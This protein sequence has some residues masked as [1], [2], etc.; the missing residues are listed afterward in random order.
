M[1][2]DELRQENERLKLQ[3]GAARGALDDLA[4]ELRQ[5]RAQTDAAERERDVHAQSAVQLGRMYT[6]A[7][8]D[9]EFAERERDEARAIV[10]QCRGLEKAKEAADREVSK[11][12]KEKNG[13]YQERDQCVA[14]MA[15]MAIALG[16]PAW[17]AQHDPGDTSWDP[18]WRTIAFIQAPT[19]QLSWHVHDS[20]VFLFDSIPSGGPPWDGHST[21]EKYTRMDAW[22]M[23][24]EPA[25]AAVSPA[26][27]TGEA[28]E[29]PT[30]TSLGDLIEAPGKPTAQEVMAKH[31]FPEPSREE[32]EAN[33]MDIEAPGKGDE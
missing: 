21:S 29:G 4:R 3:L 14:F 2:D 12:Q 19:G 10:D 13:A 27:T 9:A 22:A 7:R 1:S 30:I 26:A 11:L 32:Q 5:S 25:R 17:L 8:A 23:T 20:E 24:R 15:K 18:E 31:G 28:Y 16:W 6:T 33:L